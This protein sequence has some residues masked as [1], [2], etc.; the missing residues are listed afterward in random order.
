[1][2][3][4]PHQAVQNDREW[5]RLSEQVL[6]LPS[7]ADDPRFATNPARVAARGELHR[8]IEAA[9]SRYSADEVLARLDAA[10][11]ANGRFST[12]GNLL[13]DPQLEHC[14]TEVD[15]PAGPVRALPPP[16]RG[17]GGVAALGPIPAVGEHTGEI[18]G[19]LGYTDAEVAALRDARVV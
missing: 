8:E 11:I 1:V 13:A 18:L 3:S 4:L 5:H 12:V 10:Q 14:W 19:E 2:N 15:S 9:L 16:V 7:L 17:A 6:G